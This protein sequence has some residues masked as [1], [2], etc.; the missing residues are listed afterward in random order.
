LL[1]RPHSLPLVVQRS[2]R[3]PAEKEI[4]E[5]GRSTSSQFIQ[6]KKNDQLVPPDLTEGITLA[7][8]SD[9]FPKKFIGLEVQ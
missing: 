3:G 8:G 1:I 6:P 4:L 7:E 9:D 2:N 5:P